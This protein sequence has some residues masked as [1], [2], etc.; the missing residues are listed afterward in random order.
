MARFSKKALSESID[1][2]IEALC[3]HYNLDERNGYSQVEGEKDLQ[4][5]LAYGRLDA[6]LSLRFEFDL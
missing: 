1:Q 4:R 3:R 5:I 6:L 2:R